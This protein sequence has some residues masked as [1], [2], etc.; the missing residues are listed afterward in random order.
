MK[1]IKLE[2]WA[3]ENDVFIML[4]LSAS[5]FRSTESLAWTVD[6]ASEPS[7]DNGWWILGGKRCKSIG[8]TPNAALRSLAKMIKGK[9]IVQ[10]DAST[11][12]EQGKTLE[13]PSD[14]I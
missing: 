4:E 14:L 7:W 3:W 2:E 6:L 10:K 11:R 5:G 8:R 1:K 13:V 9:Q 12:W